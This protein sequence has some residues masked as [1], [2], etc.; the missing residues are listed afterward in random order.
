MS[1]D[2][3]TFAFFKM[4][5]CG[6]CVT[7]AEKPSAEKSGWAQLLRDPDLQSKVNFVMYEWGSVKNEKNEL[8]RYKLPEEYKFVKYGPYFYLHASKNAKNGH[9]FKPGADSPY[10][11]RSAATIKKWI[12]DNIKKDTSLSAVSQSSATRRN[13]ASTNIAPVSAARATTQPRNQ[14]RR[15][16]EKAFTDPAT[17]PDHIQ[18]MMNR[19][20]GFVQQEQEQH[21]VPIEQPVNRTF[22][23]P[24]DLPDDYQ[25]NMNRKHGFVQQEQEQPVQKPKAKETPK[26]KKYIARNR[27]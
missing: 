15:Q 2:K 13:I 16:V 10:K 11:D 26:K 7:F 14:P 21:V 27:R 5:G 19:K 4:L 17:L 23:D 25:K 9:E 22:A 12:L 1:G 18:K 3:P 8:V 6:H 24:T 20:H